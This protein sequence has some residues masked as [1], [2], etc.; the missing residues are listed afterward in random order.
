MGSFG[1]EHDR[2]ATNE[3]CD[4]CVGR[5]PI[6][7]HTGPGASEASGHAQEAGVAILIKQELA[8]YVRGEPYRDAGGRLICITLKGFSKAHQQTLMIASVYMPTGLDT[9]GTRTPE[10]AVAKQLHQLVRE[11]AAQHSLA[12]V[13]GDFNETLTKA[14]RSVNGKT[15]RSRS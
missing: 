12:I 5:N 13:A 2:R 4:A 14:D 10:H 6:S 8:C 3:G 7:G 9:M 15:T 1:V 11:K